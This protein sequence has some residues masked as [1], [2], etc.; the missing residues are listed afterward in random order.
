MAVG[1]NPLRIVVV[2][3]EYGHGPARVDR[4]ARSEMI[5]HFGLN[6]RFIRTRDY[7]SRNPHMRGTTTLLRLLFGR[8]AG[9]DHAGEFLSLDG[10]HVHIFDAF[11]LTDFLLCSAIAD[12]PSS[13]STIAIE[14][15]RG[16]RRGRSSRIMR[17]NCAHHLRHALQILEPTIIVAQGCAVRRWMSTILDHAEPAHR[18]LPLERIAFGSCHALLASFTHPSAPSR[19]NWGM[20][21]TEPYLLNVVVPTVEAARV[22]ARANR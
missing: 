13:R 22:A 3:Q 7:P 1:G 19:D 20:N 9:S 16:G 4:S 21:A 6:R 17:Q 8:S 15:L 11:A 2:G 10:R 5:R 12:S 18:T 14:S